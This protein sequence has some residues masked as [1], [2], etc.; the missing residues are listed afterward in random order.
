MIDKK[1][2]KIEFSITNFYCQFKLNL[3]ILQKL[4]LDSKS[5][6]NAIY[7]TKYN[8][9]EFYVQKKSQKLKFLLKRKIKLKNLKNLILII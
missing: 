4:A 5:E 2:Y 8:K 3:K 9:A 7:Y 6:F 1:K